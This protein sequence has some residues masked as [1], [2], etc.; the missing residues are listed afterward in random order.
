MMK[1]LLW[2]MEPLTLAGVGQAAHPRARADLRAADEA[3]RFPVAHGGVGGVGGVEG[4][5][6][7]LGPEP[8]V[9]VGDSRER[10]LSA[11]VGRCV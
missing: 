5:E 10:P 1:S 2:T 9:A 3:R 8:C 6:R 7:G 11:A 4:V